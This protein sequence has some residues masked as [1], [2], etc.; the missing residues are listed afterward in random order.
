MRLLTRIRR[1]LRRAVDVAARRTYEGPAVPQRLADEL[2]VWSALHPDE[3]RERVIAYAVWLV[4]SAYRD[5]FS[6]GY[7]WGARDWK[8]SGGEPDAAFHASER[9]AD[10]ARLISDGRDRHDALSALS[11]EERA[12]VVRE[13]S[14]GGRILR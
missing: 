3:P 5:G 7:V 6:R 12:I 8:T 2:F 10:V 14:R 11:P 4:E 13:V 9:S 1:L